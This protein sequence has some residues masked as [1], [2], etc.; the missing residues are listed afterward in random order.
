MAT[1]IVLISLEFQNNA[2][3]V[4]ERIENMK[5]KSKEELLKTLIEEHE[6]DENIMSIIAITDFMDLVN[7]EKLQ[8]FSTYFISY[9]NIG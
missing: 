1:H 8:D 4:C 5:F 6:V 7:D 3:K 2:R 9:V